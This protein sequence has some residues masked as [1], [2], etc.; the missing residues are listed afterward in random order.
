MKLRILVVLTAACATADATATLP[1]TQP[2]TTA[3][4]AA[5]PSYVKVHE[6]A[7]DEGVFA[8][9]RVS[10]DGR[11]LAYA[12]QDRAAPLP[13][14]QGQL[15]KLVDLQTKQVL[16]TE[17]GI[18]AYW[19]LDGSRFIYLSAK[20][21]DEGVTIRH[22]PGGTLTRDVAPGDLGD[23]YS[24]AVRD[25]K[26]LILTIYGNYYYLDGDRAVLPA[27]RVPSCPGIGGGERPLISKDGRRIT[28]F[29]Q[30]T[31]IVRGI[32][33]CDNIIETGIQ[34]AKAD[35]SYDGRYIAFHAPKINASGY[36]VN[37]VDLQQR[38][39]RILNDLPGSGIF[40]SWTKDGRLFFN[41]DGPDYRGFMIASNVL[42]VTAR[43]LPASARKTPDELSWADVFPETR[44][45]R[46][47]YSIVMVW[48]TWSAH[49]PD[50]LMDLQRAGA[51]L[52]ADGVDVAVMTA[53]DPVTR[54]EE[55]ERMMNRYRVT[56]PRIPL[57]AERLG[58]THGA[59]QIPATLLFR[60]G[61]LVG[62]KLGAQT[63][64]MLK[65]WI[66]GARP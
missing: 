53:L 5:A 58:L 62:R 42:S 49:A 27:A 25:G 4:S 37:I 23:Y 11:F 13:A 1:P 12:S 44:R 22:H 19:S 51:D 39:V 54:P 35:F 48:S 64:P 50:A 6:F 38:T 18:D 66:E 21:G 45:P 3:D 33:N 46:S 57:A 30:G 59:N 60:D 32:D 55:A 61:E 56:V 24:W 16:F 28:T 40:P 34:G 14:P 31:I 36:H 10:P 26:N 52:R 2:D 7:P 41:Y 15:I 20:P 63:V 65:A 17:R 9:A 29:V 43:P 47:R 8:Y